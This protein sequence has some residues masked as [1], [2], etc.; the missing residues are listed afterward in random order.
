M[1]IAPLKIGELTIDVPLLLAPMAGYTRL[2]FRMICKKFGCGLVFTE[3]VVAE[4]IVRHSPQTMRFLESLP[5][6]QPV[7]AHIYGSNLDSLVGAAQI[8]ESLGRFDAID[9]N[10]GCPV[11]KVMRKGEGVALMREPD[12]IRAIVQA[13]SQTVSLPVTV[14]T[15]LGISR[16]L[17]NISEVAHAIEEG[18]ASAIF[19]HARFA[20]DKHNGPADWETLKRIKE[21][22]SI[23]VIGNGGITRAHH[24]TD[25]LKQTGVDGVMVARAAIGNPW[26]FEEIRF[27]WSGGPYHSPSRE[28]RMTV[29]AEHLDMLYELT[30]VENETR[31]HRRQAT[32][33]D[34]CR[35]FR[36]HLVAYLANTRGLRHLRKRLME[37]S[38]RK[39]VMAAVDEVLNYDG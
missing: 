14:K 22:R 15:R 29:I 32:E 31:K 38:S 6:E 3:M 28:K 19:L 27:L 23:P 33:R 2:P 26:I 16:E 21:E 12:K 35:R 17:F 37:M 9:I 4:G 1:K 7:A 34:V 25:M 20:S 30:M 5:E 39:A 8:V 36:S 10:C 24:A 13:M 18:G 11:P